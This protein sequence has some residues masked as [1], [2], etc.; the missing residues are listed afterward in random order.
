MGGAAL[1]EG[2]VKPR[3]FKTHD[4]MVAFMRSQASKGKAWHMLILHDDGCSPARCSCQPWYEV[5]PLT[6]DNYIE[7]QKAQAQWVK[8]STS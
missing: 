4:G 3:V 6:V 1:R 8:E 5:R 2:R 7:G